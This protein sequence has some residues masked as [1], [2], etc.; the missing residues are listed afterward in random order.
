[1]LVAGHAPF[2]W[3]KSAAEAAYHAVV[4]EEVA[5]LAMQTLAV[6]PNAAPIS[7]AMAD[8]HFYRKHGAS[9]YLRTAET[10]AKRRT[11]MAPVRLFLTSDTRGI[12]DCR[13]WR[14]ANQ[15]PTKEEAALTR[16]ITSEPWGKT[17]AG[18]AVE[19]Y[20]LTNAKGA[21]ARITT[22]GGIVV[23]LKVPDRAG[24]MGDVVARIRQPGRLSAAAS[25]ALLRRA[26]RTLRQSHRQGEVHARTARNTRWPRT[27]ATI[28]SMAGCEAS[29]RWS[30]RPKKAPGQSLE[31]TYLSKDGEEGY[32]GNLTSTVTYTLTDNNELK[33]DYPATTD[34]TT[35]VNLTNHAYFNLAGPGEGD[36]LGHMVTINADKF[37]PVDKGLIPT[38]ELK[39]VA[40]T[41]FDFRTPH[42]IG[43][44]IGDKGRADRLRRR[45]R[46]QLGAESH[47]HRTGTGGQGDRAQ[48]RAA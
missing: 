20:T 46:P 6:N 16:K 4:L 1:M 45:L 36:I 29:T 30:G 14:H 44:R 18:E 12:I 41:P 3:G 5:N 33:I 28:I 7:Q 9:A 42:A 2:A 40:G 22:Y 10:L 24:A 13:L 17:A 35:V 31:L 48:D 32:P 34:K 21:E 43:E 15:S 47:R 11:T 25:A 26:D 38:G 19:L 27:T 37:T 8:K 39:D 23:S